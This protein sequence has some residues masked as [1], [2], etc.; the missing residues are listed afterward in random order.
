MNSTNLYTK[1]MHEEMMFTLL[2][3]YWN[4]KTPVANQYWL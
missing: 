2:I 1:S 3:L 4:D